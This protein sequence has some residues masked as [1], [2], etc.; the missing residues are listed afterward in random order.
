MFQSSSDP[1]AGCDLLAR[2]RQTGADDCFNP[3]PTRRPD[4]T[5]APLF[6]VSA[7]L[8][9][10]S[11]DPKAGCDDLDAPPARIYAMFQSS[12]DPKAGCDVHRG[13]RAQHRRLVSILIRPE[14]RMRPARR[15]V[16]ARPSG[17]QS[18]SDP[19]AGCDAI[20]FFS[21]HNVLFVSILIRPEGRMRREMGDAVARALVFQ[22][23]SDPKAGCD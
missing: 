19:K 6:E 23:S 4:A 11:S 2:G 15:R 12:S 16:D 10:S 22:S 17:F 14:G 1:K 21:N 20:P 5:A 7:R 3:H 9:Q 8:F 18:S 13:R